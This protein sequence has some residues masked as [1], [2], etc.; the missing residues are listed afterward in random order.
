MAHS[1]TWDES[2]PNG[3]STAASDIDLLFRQLKV[4]IR[5][6]LVDLGVTDWATDDPNKFASIKLS[7]GCIITVSGAS[8]LIASP[9]GVTV[10][11]QVDSTGNT[12]SRGNHNVGGQ[13][14]TVLLAASGLASFNGGIAVV[15]S[16]AA[17]FDGQ[18]TFLD[19]VI[20]N[21]GQANIVPQN[22]VTTGPAMTL[23]FAFG[24]IIHLLLNHTVTLTLSSPQPG[25][26]YLIK[27]TQDGVGGR[28]VVWPANVH[29]PNAGTAPAMS[30]TPGRSDLFSLYY[31]GANFLGNVVAYGYDV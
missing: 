22:G 17:S 10:N 9:D 18:V 24:N 25:A 14:N 4:D 5:E 30:S 11:F 13:L 2:A 29:W 27:F 6:R 19:R 21:T 16:P 23:D 31:D 20:L 8:I 28:T 1:R 3:A 12:A 7:N 26:H 15:G